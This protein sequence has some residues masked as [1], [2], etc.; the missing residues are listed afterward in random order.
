MSFSEHRR[1]GYSDYGGRKVVHVLKGLESEGKLSI[2]K[3][4]IEM[5][6]R[7]A[8]VE[9]MGQ[10]QGINSYD[11]AYMSFGFLQWPI[12][13]NN[14]HGGKLQRLVKTIPQSFAKY[15]IELDHSR[16]W[17]FKRGRS[18][19]ISIPFKGIR[20]AKELRSSKWAKSFYLAGID[21]EVIVAEVALALIV[22]E[23]NKQRIER[24]VGKYFLSHYQ[25][26]NVLRA[27]I[28]ESFNH[29][30]AWLYRALKAAIRQAKQQ[31]G[32]DTQRFLELTRQ[33]IQSVWAAKGKAR[34]GRNLVRKTGRLI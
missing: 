7:M 16:K 12:L 17:K 24:K 21:A 4:D 19:Y 25:N 26:S 31:S 9:S 32:V 8:N 18:T 22:I 5:L 10:I 27:L 11:N 2:S 3:K 1:H 15:G 33:A 6:Q 13:Y 34:S 23:E 29:R 30:P 14:R 20:Y 28:Q